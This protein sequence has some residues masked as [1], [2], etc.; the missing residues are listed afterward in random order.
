MAPELRLLMSLSGSGFMFHLTNSMFKQQPLPGVE[1]VLRSN[2]ELMKQFQQAASQ[3][4][5]NLQQ[6]SSGQMPSMP[7]TPP[8]LP[9][10]QQGMG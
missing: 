5:A 7:Q 1:Q 4:A 2:P 6:M 10:Q 3:Q 9:A 8:Q